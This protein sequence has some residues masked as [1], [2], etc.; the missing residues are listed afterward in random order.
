[1]SFANGLQNH[2]L[3]ELCDRIFHE[4]QHPFNMDCIRIDDNEAE[5]EEYERL[6]E[7]F[8]GSDEV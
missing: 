8:E 3:A 5:R 1:M 4:T 2:E 7:Q 6:K